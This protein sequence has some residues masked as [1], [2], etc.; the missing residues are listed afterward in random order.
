MDESVF[1]AFC[2][3]I[4]KLPVRQRRD[5]GQ[6]LRTLDARIEVLAKIDKRRE[7]IDI[8]LH[9]DDVEI[10][11]WGDAAT[12]PRQSAAQRASGSRPHRVALCLPPP[13]PFASLDIYWICIGVLG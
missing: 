2:L 6:M 11:R 13:L 10:Q 7:P 8:C 4:E 9:C 5:L 1:K 3:G 12:L